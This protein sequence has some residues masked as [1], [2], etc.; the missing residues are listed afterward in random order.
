MRTHRSV[1][2]LLFALACLVAGSL[3]ARATAPG[4]Y[5]ADTNNHRIVFMADI[6]GAGWATVG[7]FGSGVKQLDQPTAVCIGYDGKIY[8]VDHNNNRIVRMDD[9]TGAGWVAL[10]SQGNGVKQFDGPVG[11]A[12]GKDG[13]LYIADTANHRIVRVDDI[14]GK[15]WTILGSEGPGGKQFHDPHGIAIDSNGKIYVADIY[16]QRIVRMDDITGAGWATLGRDKVD[17]MYPNSLSLDAAGNLF[18]TDDYQRIICVKPGLGM[19][20]AGE[21][22]KGSLQFSSPSSVCVTADGKIAVAD[23]GNNRITQMDDITGKGWQTFGSIGN[24]NGQFLTPTDIVYFPGAQAPAQAATSKPASATD[25]PV[26]AQFVE[27]FV[28]ENFN[29]DRW[30][31][32]PFA[33]TDGA[34]IAIAG[35]GSTHGLRVNLDTTK[36]AVPVTFELSTANPLIDLQH[37]T[38]IDLM[39]DWR[40]VTD[41][42]GLTAGFSLTPADGSDAQQDRLRVMLVGENG[43]AAV[44]IEVTAVIGGEEYQ[45]ATGLPHEAQ[46]A[47][48]HLRISLAAKDR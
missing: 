43:Q 20:V 36:Q 48:Q 9:M 15:G 45:I 30:K 2:S 11:L 10:G 4:Y 22:G 44:H 6:T 33:G 14:T 7:S 27:N 37:R 31:A 1:L 25:Q 12:I 46:S 26:P 35:Q 13:K 42:A 8:V 23:T 24:G 5:I 19:Q 29:P 32:I 39:I 40:K 16:N 18:L 38:V 21:E 47:V 34:M 28:S 17:F 41:G 3:V